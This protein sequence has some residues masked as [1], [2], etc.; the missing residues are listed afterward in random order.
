LASLVI[1]DRF[2]SLTKIARIA[3]P[4]VLL[5]GTR[6]DVVPVAMGRRLAAARPGSRWVETP[7]ATHNDFPGLA[8]LLAHEI[9]SILSAP[10]SPTRP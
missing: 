1:R 9:E 2:D 7:E 8:D 3:S 10:L 4:V 6:D 5:H